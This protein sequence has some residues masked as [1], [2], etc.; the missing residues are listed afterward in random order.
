[1][2]HVGVPTGWFCLFIIL[3][4]ESVKVN[5]LAK[6]NAIAWYYIHLRP[7]FASTMLDKHLVNLSINFTFKDQFKIAI[8]VCP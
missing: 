4:P 6:L 8:T 2:Q 7:C 3:E 1:M 5:P